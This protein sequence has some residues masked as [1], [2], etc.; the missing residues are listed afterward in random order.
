MLISSA[1]QPDTGPIHTEQQIIL[2]YNETELMK[3]VCSCYVT[4][5]RETYW[6]AFYSVHAQKIPRYGAFQGDKEILYILY[7]ESSV[8]K[9]STSRQLVGD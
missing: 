8:F 7:G 1:K 6:F 3:G 2:A 4:D 9:S 5:W